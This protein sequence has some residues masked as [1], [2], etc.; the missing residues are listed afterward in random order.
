M[1]TDFRV[2][3]NLFYASASDDIN[4]SP[5]YLPD[6]NLFA[7]RNVNCHPPV[8][9]SFSLYPPANRVEEQR[10]THAPGNTFQ[11]TAGKQPGN[12]EEISIKLPNSVCY[13]PSE[14]WCYLCY[15]GCLKRTLPT[16]LRNHVLTAGSRLQEVSECVGEHPLADHHIMFH[17]YSL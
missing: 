13:E 7:L 4:A 17:E 16:A 5:F 1:G 9:L 14:S 8:S 6:V 15:W 2:A 12:N 3:T 10:K 11:E